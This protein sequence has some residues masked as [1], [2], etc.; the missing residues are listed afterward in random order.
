M[1]TAIKRIQGLGVFGDFTPTAELPEFGRYN[2]VYGENGSGKTTLSRLFGCLETGEHAEYADLQFSIDSQSGVLAKGQRYARKVR[3]FNSDYVEANIG[4]FHAPLRHILII[5]EDNKALAD[6]VVAEKKLHGERSAAIDVAQKAITKLDSDKGKVFSA[7]AKTIGEATSGSTLRSYRKPDAEAAYANERGLAPLSDALLEVHRATVHQEQLDVITSPTLA[8]YG[9]GPVLPAGP[10]VDIAAALPG[11]VSALLARTAQAGVLRRLVEEPAIAV[12]VE[13]GVA[14]HRDHGS[15][16]CEFCDQQL[17]PAR[18]AALAEHFGV[19]DQ[20]LKSDILAALN[21][22]HALRDALGVLELPAR[23]ALYAE[24][25]D[26]YETACQVITRRRDEVVGQLDA[27]AALLKDKLLNRSTAS[28]ATILIDLSL[29]VAA[30]ATLA[31]LV[32]R[33]NRKS[34]EF[35]AAKADARAQ[36]QRHY[37]ST[38]DVQVRDLDQRI[39]AQKAIVSNLTDGASDL[40]DP[41]SLAAIRVSYETK[42]AQVSSEHAGGAQMTE[43]L[44]DFLGRTDLRFESSN[45]GYR[46]LR[47]GKAAKRLSEGEKT[48]IA[49]LYFIVQLG[50]QDFDLVEGIVV[51]DDPISSMDAASIYQAFA[52]L[53]N[54]VKDAKQIFLLTHN[55][56]FLKLLLNWLKSVPRSVGTKSYYM[57]VCSES[58]TSREACLQPLD[59]LLLDHPSEYNFLFKLLHDFKSDGT[60]LAAYHIPNVARKVLETFLEF[61]RPFENSV[62]AKLESTTFDPHKKTAIYKFSNDLSH[63]TGKGFDPALVAETQK[64]VTFLL[65]MIKTLEPLHYEGLEKLVTS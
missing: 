16:H 19:E 51:I 4:Q 35:D 25:R 8:S 34:A 42:Q 15:A 31:A 47:R 18:M 30:I 56:D 22:V 53:K 2:I 32:E 57:I 17:P 45:E 49:F 52:F 41:R 9:G 40:P 50:D 23:T 48:A 59:K 55:F 26:E 3:V 11:L 29:L 63:P 24:L 33:H 65:E 13:Q 10:F 60:I 37:L 5:G 38:I 36:I 58:E 20:H 21:V 61:H 28:S 62:Y 46:V 54:A 1:L 64:N 39:A 44:R 12:W 6:D 7:I 43:R 27:V 14:L